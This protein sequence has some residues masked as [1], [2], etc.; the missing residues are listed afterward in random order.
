MKIE[1]KSQPVE[2]YWVAKAY[3]SVKKGGQATGV[4]G[5]SMEGF[6]KKLNDNLYKLWDRLS[7]GSYMPPPIREQEI[8]KSD[9]QN[10][11]L[12]IPT[13]SDRIAQRVVKDY[14]EPKLEK[15][16]HPSSYGY[17]PPKNAHQALQ[18]CVGHCRRYS[19][20]IDLDIK[21]FFDNLDHELLMRAVSH[22]FKERWIL[23]YVERWLKA[24]IIQADGQ[25]RTRE[26]GTPQGGVISPLLANLFLHY[27]I[28]HWL[29]LH[30]SEI[31]FERYADDS[32]LHCSSK[33]EAETLLSK[34]KE[35][36]ENLKLELHGSKT[37][38][39]YCKQSRRQG[40]FS[41][42]SFTFLGHYF[43]PHKARTREGRSFLSF[44]PEISKSAAKGI[45]AEL[46]RMRI[47]RRT[48]KTIEQLAREL[49]PKLRGWISYYRSYG[50]SKFK[51]ILHLLNIRLLKWVRWRHKLRGRTG[52]IIDK[53]LGYYQANPNLFAYWKMGIK[54]MRAH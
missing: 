32:V 2:Y 47:H 13:V 11:K 52:K 22:H 43:R 8:P 26:Q 3:R 31:R 10:R 14:M 12:G 21:G 54:P 51:Y 44:G 46:R 25:K 45:I 17:R 20:V 53:M 9:G 6:E 4:D 41:E 37:K 42:V 34:L 50:G 39:V 29:K 35:R 7:S 16:F 40:S 23:L 15:V 24:P 5:Q 36:V 33:T 19:W 18:S 38:I 28:D 1:T 48:G 30:H 49:N 27:A